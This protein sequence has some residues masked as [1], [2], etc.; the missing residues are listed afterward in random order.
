MMLS[1]LLVILPLTV[2]AF[3]LP[4]GGAFHRSSL[5]HSDPPSSVDVSDL[6]LT[7]DDFN[8]PLPS[9]LL[10]GLTSSGCESTNRLEDDGGC[11]W[12]ENLDA[13]SVKLQIP[14]LR[15]QPP[16]AVAVLFS[17]TTMSVSVFG[18]VVW[19]AVLR[20]TVDPEGCSFYEPDLGDNFVPVIRVNVKKEESKLW[21]G[22]ILQIGEN[23]IL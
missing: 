7:M 17:T 9:E 10:E 16:A 15:G 13:M 11:E 5:L 3:V 1:R 21:G 12:S 22:Y 20:G 6:G 19:S 23:S 18:R 14:G 8:K 4:N 2:S